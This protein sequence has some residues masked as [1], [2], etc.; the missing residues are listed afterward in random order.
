LRPP[1]AYSTKKLSFFTKVLDLHVLT[2][3]SEVYP[4]GWSNS[5]NRVS[6]DCANEDYPLLYMAN[7]SAHSIA[8]NQRGKLYAWGWNDN[9]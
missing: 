8:V 1:T 5:W 9:G 7:G 6:G 3:L 2:D 4:K